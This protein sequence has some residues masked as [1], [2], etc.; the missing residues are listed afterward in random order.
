MTTEFYRQERG[1]PTGPVRSLTQPNP[2]EAG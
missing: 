2:K 1:P